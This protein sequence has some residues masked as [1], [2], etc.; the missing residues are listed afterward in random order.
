MWDPCVG[1]RPEYYQK[2]E[3]VEYAPKACDTWPRAP[4]KPANEVV[5]VV[6]SW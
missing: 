5:V 4:Y 2:T 6:E 3:E 1:I